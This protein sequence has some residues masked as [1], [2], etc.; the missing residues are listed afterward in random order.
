MTNGQ[1]NLY[2]RSCIVLCHKKVKISNK[3]YKSQNL[4]KKVFLSMRE[5]PTD[6]VNFMLDTCW[7]RASSDKVAFATNYL[8]K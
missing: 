8:V 4:E 7:Y 1:L 5:R 3:L 6:Q 2:S